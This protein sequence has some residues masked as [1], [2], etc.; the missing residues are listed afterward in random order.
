METPPLISILGPT[1]CGKT[2]LAV[3]VALRLQGEILSADSRQVYRGMDIGTGKDLSE[4]QTA[5][6]EVPYHLIDIL[7]AGE[8]YSLFDYQRDFHT[9]HAG[10]VSRGA[11]PILCGG[12]GL[13]A[14][15]ILR[16]YQLQEVPPNPTLREEL[17]QLPTEE[18]IKRLASYV[19]LHNSTDTS[20]RARLI[21]ALEIA[22]TTDE[23]GDKPAI[24]APIRIGPSFAIELPRA[25]RRNRISQRLHARLAE[26]LIGEVE[27]LLKEGV[28]H[29]T[30]RYYGLEYRFV[31]EY[32][33]GERSYAGMVHGLE[34]AIHQ[35]AKR[36]M[37]YLRGMERRGVRLI[38]LDG[39]ADTKELV[40]REIVPRLREYGIR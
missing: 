29:A 20:S 35:F 4:Y 1:A 34:I 18:L 27:V 19:A 32:L 40:E 31:T 38:W 7:E 16:D 11:T 15:A 26:G 8:K 17:Q 5:H 9:A 33:M 13:Y 14:E 24:Y 30:L 22:I 36:Q 21:R 25:L 3:Q 37:T 6:G 12:S 10:I 23:Q 39:T 2:H 28:P